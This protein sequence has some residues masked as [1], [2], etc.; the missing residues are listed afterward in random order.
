MKTRNE[1]AYKA[2]K[3]A[4]EK[5][6]WDEKHSP[7]HYLMLVITE[8]GEAVEAW[9]KNK[10]ADREAYD[11]RTM[12]GFDSKVFEMYIKDSDADE[13]AD[14]Y[15]RLLDLAEGFDYKLKPRYTEREKLELLHKL[16]EIEFTEQIFS[17]VEASMKY[18]LDGTIDLYLG[19]LLDHIEATAEANA[20]DL[21]WHIEEKMRYNAIRPYLHGNKC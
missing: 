12:N 9:R 21:A 19:A 4:A 14:A 17:I 20:I 8:L 13:L 3:N 7:E 5:G 15:I 18:V 10:R 16:S 2:H 1:F 11:S 6:F